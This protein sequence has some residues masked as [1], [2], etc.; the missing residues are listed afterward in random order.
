M[1]SIYK[2][3]IC[4][5][6]LSGLATSCSD[7]LGLQPTSSISAESFWKTENDAIAGANTMYVQLRT[8]ASNQSQSYNTYFLGEARSDM[9]VLGTAGSLGYENYYDN[10]L[11]SSVSGP[12]WVG[13]Y[14][15]V[16]S[17]N[18]LLKYLPKIEM[19]A[20]SRNALLAEAYTMRAYV[21]F[22][23]VRSWGDLVI[24]TEPLEKYDPADVQRERSPKE[25]V[26]KLIKSDLDAALSLFPNNTFP[27]GRAKW[28][29]PAANALKAEVF[30]WTGKR[31]NGGTADFT[32]ALN[33]INEVQTAAPLNLLPNFAD[34]F[35]T[36]GNNEI[37]MA[38]RLADGE[39]ATGYTNYMYGATVAPCTPQADKDLIGVQGN[40]TNHSW[41]LSP[42]VRNAFTNDDSRKRATFVDV[43]SYDP[44]KPTLC[45]QMAYVGTIT[46]KFK[47]TVINGAR[48]FYDDILIFRYA[49][50]LLMKA[51]AKNALG[52]DPST[53]INAVRQRAYGANYPVHIFA[54]G[55]QVQNDTAILQERLLELAVE[56]KRWWDL[57][58]FGKAFDL[59]P[60]LQG[61][62][63]QDY[64]LLFPIGGPVLSLEPKVKQ[65]PGY[66]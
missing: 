47:G 14:A 63:G 41:Q 11:N 44:T 49:D 22:I 40:T 57:V 42:A 43:Y 7:D 30:L 51:E 3:L 16:N 61:R 23:M 17:C 66:N 37:I 46:L 62:A 38:I 18:L 24:R 28:S 65:N 8:Q 55:S 10:K 60:S 32:T 64:L 36:K 27:A 1:K 45:I 12:S 56:G 25:E 4:I 21:Y 6:L 58:R 50:L 39:G 2:I 52:Q 35:S 9:L 54:N 31:L 19:S 34:V 59:V 13:Y 33:A 29:K 5:S 20:A 48:Q 26:F 15:I 53:E